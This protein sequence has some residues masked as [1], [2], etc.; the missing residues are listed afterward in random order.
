MRYRRVSYRYTMVVTSGQPR[1]FRGQPLAGGLL[2]AGGYP[3]V[4]L[5][6]PLWRPPADVYESATAVTVTV[7]LA[8]VDQ[9]ALE[10]TLFDDAV[11]VEGRRRIECPSQTEGHE[12]RG[13]YHA[14]EIYQG[15]IRV[16][17]ALPAPVDAERV[18]AHS[19]RGLLRIHLPKPVRG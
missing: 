19:D 17:V 8:G 2:G 16:E 11:V 3:G 12:G 4:V 14:A 1:P 5:A 6:Q 9:D 18:S 13:V 7:E 10:V 15:P